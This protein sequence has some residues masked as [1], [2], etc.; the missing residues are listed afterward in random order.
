MSEWS[1]LRE[2]TTTLKS[3]RR[4]CCVT[5]RALQERVLFSPRPPGGGRRHSSSSGAAGVKTK[6]ATRRVR[7]EH[8]FVDLLARVYYITIT[9]RLHHDYITITG[10]RVRRPP[11]ARA[12]ARDQG[13]H[14]GRRARGGVR[15]VSS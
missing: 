5:A 14:L 10:A 8:E 4:H 1:T 12:R 7:Q 6:R 13:G 11:R 15:V 2:G 9:S 3:M